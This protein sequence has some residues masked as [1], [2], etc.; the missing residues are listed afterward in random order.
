[1]FLRPRGSFDAVLLQEMEII[2][3]AESFVFVAAYYL[4]VLGLH[5]FRCLLHVAS[6]SLTPLFN[7]LPCRASAVILF[8]GSFL[9]QDMF[10]RL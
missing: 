1:M 8:L 9:L 6:Q 4:E 2:S 10:L 5:G 7:D 3:R